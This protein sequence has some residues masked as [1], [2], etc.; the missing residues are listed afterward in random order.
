MPTL[1]I[2]ELPL[3]FPTIQ[4]HGEVLSINTNFTFHFTDRFLESEQYRKELV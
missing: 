3:N 2:H 4:P 1:R